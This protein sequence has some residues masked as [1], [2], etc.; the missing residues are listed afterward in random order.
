MPITSD[1]FDGLSEDADSPTAGTNADRILSFLRTNPETAFTQSEIAANTGVKTGSVGPTL[2]RL[3]ERGRVDHRETYWRISDHEQ[4]VDAAG[5]HAAATL[6]E[7]E[8]ADE[9]PVLNEWEEH[10]VDPRTR[11]NDE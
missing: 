4:S 9:T 6:G 1:Q 8:Y 5:E 10:A 7:Q 11:R 3:R 2:V